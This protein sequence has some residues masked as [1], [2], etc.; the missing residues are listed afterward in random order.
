M[1]GSNLDYDANDRIYNVVEFNR[2]RLFG[3]TLQGYARIEAEYLVERKVD[4]LSCRTL[5]FEYVEQFVDTIDNFVNR[6][7]EIELGFANL[8]ADHRN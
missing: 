8:A 4:N 5:N 7:G 3:N 1:L 6:N 2:F